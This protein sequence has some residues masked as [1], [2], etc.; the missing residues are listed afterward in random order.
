MLGSTLSLPLS[1][2][3]VDEYP[4]LPPMRPIGCNADPVTAT[5]SLPFHADEHFAGKPASVSPAIRDLCVDCNLGYYILANAMEPIVAAAGRIGADALD[6]GLAQ[7]VGIAADESADWEVRL[8]CGNLLIEF[9]RDGHQALVDSL[10][11]RDV[12]FARSFEVEDI[13]RAYGAGKDVPCWMRFDNSWMFYE[14]QAIVE[15][16]E[17][18][19]EEAAR[20]CDDE[21]LDDEVAMGGAPETYVREMPKIGRNDPCSCGGGRKYKK[22]CLLSQKIPS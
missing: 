5:T 10:A 15:R 17:R 12:G 18:W 20:D 19:V 21:L 22:C 8:S 2:T 6:D 9:P 4:R 3:A 14:P 7:A 1:A 11:K 16:R 13:E